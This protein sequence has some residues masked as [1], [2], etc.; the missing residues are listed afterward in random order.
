[1]PV[2]YLSYFPTVNFDVFRR[3]PASFKQKKLLAHKKLAVSIILPGKY[4]DWPGNYK[5]YD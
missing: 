1:M 4:F 5:I 3:F 2:F